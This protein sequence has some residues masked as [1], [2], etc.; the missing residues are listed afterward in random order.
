MVKDEVLVIEKVNGNSAE[1]LSALSM[2]YA[3]LIGSRSL[4]L[5]LLLDA[6]ASSGSSSL[7]TLFLC[8]SMQIKPSELTMSRKELEQFMLLRTYQGNDGLLIR[9]CPPL[10]PLDFLRHDVFGRLYMKQ[11]GR[12]M[13]EFMQ[14][15]FTQGKP[16]ETYTEISEPFRLADWF[17]WQEEEEN[18]FTAAKPKPES[19]PRITFSREL[20]LGYC[21]S[22]TFPLTARS[23]DNLA[24]IEQIGS[25]YGVSEQDMV[26]LVAKNI[27]LRT[28]QLNVS[29]LRTIISRKY[30]VKAE[31][32]N[33]YLL[34]CEKF[35]LMKQNG[36][37]VTPADKRLLDYLQDELKMPKEVVNVLVEHVLNNLNQSLSKSYVERIAGSWVRLN[38][39]TY[40]KALAHVNKAAEVKPKR[41]PAAKKTRQVVTNLPDWYTGKEQDQGSNE[42]ASIDQQEREQLL[43]ELAKM[44]GE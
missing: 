42:K 32:S 31:E 43:A 38:I 5:Y 35:L 39:D 8:E 30:E 24:Q 28:Q 3:P 20:F 15:R 14:I 4:H 6:L 22:L 33:P 36:V 25:Y 10:A 21:T 37:P 27:N 23:E 18:K 11:L 12:K 26:P 34:P 7:S 1:D 29:K 16:D 41:K 17:E 2:L 44:R 9:I 19:D 13:Y 40:E